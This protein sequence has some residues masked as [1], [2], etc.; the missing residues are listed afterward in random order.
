[1]RHILLTL[2]VATAAVTAC[3]SPRAPSATPRNADVITAEELE[4]ANIG[5]A[6]HAIERLR[7]RFLRVRGPSSVANASADR[8]IVYV[9]NT[10]MGYVDVLREIQADDI[11]EIRY[12]SASDATSRFGTGHTAGAILVTRK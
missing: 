6:Y 12:L 11:R 3:G 2:L 8:V 7:P 5:N 4:R 9:D 1:M 10:R